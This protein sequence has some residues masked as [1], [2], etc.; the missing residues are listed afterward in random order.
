M[1]NEHITDYLEYFKKL[2]NPQYAVLLKGA[3]GCGKTYFIQNLVESWEQ[4]NKEEDAIVIQPLYLSLNGINDI[5]TINENLKALLHPFL[6]SKGV[7]FMKNLFFGVVKA[8]AKVNLDFDDDD[9]ADGNI[10]INFNPI[11]LITSKSDKIKG[12]KIIV[13]DDLERCK[14]ATDELFGY[15]NSFVE[16]HN[17]KVILI[18]DEKKIELKYENESDKNT[19]SYKDFKEKLIGQTFEISS[20]TTNAIVKFIEE[21]KNQEV[22]D[23]LEIHKSIIIDL[24]NS[25]GTQ[26]L[27]VLK[28]TLLEFSRFYELVELPTNDENK[29]LFWENMLCYFIIT[30][31]EF[32]QGNKHV[33]SFQSMQMFNDEK[34]S[35]LSKLES[36]YNRVLTSNKILHSS[37]VFPINN[38]VYFIENGFINKDYLKKTISSNHFFKVSEAQPWER[39]WNW[40]ELGNDE[41]DEEFNKVWNSFSKKEV[42]RTNVLLHITGILLTLTDNKIIQNKKSTI[43]SL[44]KENINSIF[45]KEEVPEACLYIGISYNKEYQSKDSA[46]FNEVYSFAYDKITSY[47]HE[48]K[49]DFLKTHFENLTEEKI[50]NIYTLLK[51]STPDK[52]TIYEFTPIFK[53]VNGHKLAESLLGLSNKS[54]QEFNWFLQDR[55][56]PQRR[57]VNCQLEKY[58]LDEI[59]CLEQLSKTLDDNLSTFEKVDRYS[60]A[61]LLDGLIVVLNELKQYSESIEQKD[62]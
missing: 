15:I 44:A 56:F 47:Q 38:I 7:K 10:A 25:S 23:L 17:C 26:N 39:L 20:D 59:I 21:I 34:K 49:E 53:N 2:S 29:D 18:A 35:E 12:E 28:Q 60:V 24:F 57:C 43:V 33:S 41:F 27:R 40:N 32:K 9:K 11:D 54:K 36:K 4:E 30:C 42:D 52:K 50:E 46:E 16:H 61:S 3:W 55:Y 14:V 58:H 45:K 6:Y 19:I 51:S 37:N 62:N 5:S 31:S 1:T 48:S 22:K 13:F 8:A